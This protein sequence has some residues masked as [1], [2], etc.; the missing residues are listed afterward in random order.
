MVMAT[1]RAETREERLGPAEGDE[2][3]GRW[4]ERDWAER[5]G[6]NRAFDD[7][8]RN[9]RVSM[10]WDFENCEVP[11]GVNVYRIAQCITA[12]VRENGINGPIQI[13]AFGDVF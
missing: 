10:W 8:S 9:V 4:A 5:G 13:N 11:T 7:T 3:G 1:R 12:A 2:G 6:V